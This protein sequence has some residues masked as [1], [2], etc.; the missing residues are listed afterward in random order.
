LLY[1]ENAIRG[2][3]TTASAT[4]RYGDTGAAVTAMQ[5]RLI[6]LGYMSGSAD[7]NFGLSTRTALLA[8]QKANKLTRDGVAGAKTLAALNATGAVSGTVPA[9]TTL[10]VGAVGDAVKQLQNRLITLGYLKA[11]SADGT[12]G[13]NTSMALISF[14]KANGLTPD[15]MAGAKTIARLNAGGA[16]SGGNG[17]GIAGV[18]PGAPGV[19]GVNAANVRYANWYTEVKARCKLYPNA[20]VYD[21]TNGISWQVNMFSL[22]AHADSEPLTAADTA[23]MNRAFGGKTTWTPKAVWIVFSDGRIY[24]AST[25]NTPHE[26][27]HIRDNNFPGH[28]CIHFPR[29]QTQVDLS[30]KSD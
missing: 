10:K 19:S 6:E 7:G 12:F 21:F 5:S 8:F 17:G 23:N 18:V 27:S 26:T 24:M 9:D 1:S 15:G 2:N 25:H 3:P 28:L 22:G 30:S 14:Q 11:G 29:T 13:V 20:T 4:L 16:I